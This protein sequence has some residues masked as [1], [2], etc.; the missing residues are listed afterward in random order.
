MFVY[1]FLFFDFLDFE[2]EDLAGFL[3]VDGTSFSRVSTTVVSFGGSAVSFASVLT[4][5]SSVL[6]IASVFS[7][8][9]AFSKSSRDFSSAFVSSPGIV[10]DLR[11]VLSQAQVHIQVLKQVVR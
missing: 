7:S 8:A 1:Y 9:L 5:T 4:T 10:E 11:Q 2:A 6:T 3:T